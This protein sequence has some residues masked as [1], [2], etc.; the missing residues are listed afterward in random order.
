MK[1]AVLL[2][3][4][5]LV[6]LLLT[7]CA[8]AGGNPPVPAE[9]APAAAPV[10][11]DLDLSGMS[12]TVVYGMVYQ[13][14]T[15][16]E[17]FVGKHVRMKGVF[18]SYYDNETKQRFFGC[19]ISDALACCSQGLA[20]ELAKPRKFPEEFPDEGTP[21]IITGDFDLVKEEDEGSYPIIRNAKMSNE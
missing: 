10:T 3:V 2:P 13:M 12:G 16:P 14:V 17:R 5:G 18:S 9:T 20:F 11:V 15:T 21:I 1:K 4:L 8:P 6:I 19:V 7:S